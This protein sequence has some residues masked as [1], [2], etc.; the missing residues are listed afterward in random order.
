MTKAKPKGQ[1]KER[2]GKPDW[3]TAALKLLGEKGI[4]A[5]TIDALC[6][7]LDLTKGSF[8]WHFKGRQDLL[9]AMADSWATTSTVEIHEQLRNSGLN[10]WEQLREI[11]RM[12]TQLGYGNID[13]AMR[14][15]AER[16]KET[17]AAV[18]Q[19]DKDIVAFIE[20]K[21]VN[22]G[23]SKKDAR[24]FSKLS[25]ACSVGLFAV[26]SSLKPADIKNINT[27][28][29]TMIESLKNN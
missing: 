8:Y 7:R 26:G 5:V 1:K 23:L 25:H 16:C 12:S 10:D 24:V 28:L 18:H 22:T 13:R 9:S 21:L 11:N 15:W 17:A 3:V 2:S 4:D 6:S 29:V 27:M 14:I 20:E 19:A